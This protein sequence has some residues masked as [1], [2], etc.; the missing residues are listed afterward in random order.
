MRADRPVVKTYIP[1]APDRS[2]VLRYTGTRVPS[3][4]VDALLTDCLAELAGRLAFRV[5]YCTLPVRRIE[6]GELDLDFAKT[7]SRALSANLSGCDSAILFAATLGEGID[8]LIARY[9]VLAPAKALLLQAI[10][11]ERVEALCDC[12]IADMAAIAAAEGGVLRPRFSPGYG[13]LP[14]DLQKQV[15]ARLDCARRIGLCLNDSLLMSPS[16]SVT[17]LVGIQK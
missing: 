15:F 4:E 14:L 17:A 5:V 9:A 2:E 8:R 3:A 11:A 13:D 7:S 10:G 12:F 1:P 16:K 6:E